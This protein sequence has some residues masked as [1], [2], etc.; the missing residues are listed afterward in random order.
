MKSVAY[1]SLKI[2]TKFD[3][4]QD[5]FII[6]TEHKVVFRFLNI[7]YRQ[8]KKYCICKIIPGLRFQYQV[9]FL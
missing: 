8:I 5:T 9:F 1:A 4:N 6:F 7:P 2:E 3:Y